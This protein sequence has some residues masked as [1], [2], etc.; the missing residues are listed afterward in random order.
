MTSPT[1]KP[2]PANYQRV[3]PRFNRSHAEEMARWAKDP[4]LVQG[5]F[6]AIVFQDALRFGI[7]GE[8]VMADLV[9]AIENCR[10]A[11]F[12]AWLDAHHDLLIQHHEA[13]APDLSIGSTP[14]LVPSEPPSGWRNFC[15]EAT[16]S[17]SPP[18]SGP[19]G[20]Q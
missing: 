7:C 18:K 10:W 4:T 6:Y 3:R 12:K 19:H 11:E 20:K 14:S 17:T 5:M 2:L 1:P 8:D 9:E 15:D 16:S 13:K